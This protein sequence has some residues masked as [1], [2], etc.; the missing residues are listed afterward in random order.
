[1][2]LTDAPFFLSNPHFADSPNAVRLALAGVRRATDAERSQVAIDIFTGAVVEARQTYQLNTVF[3]GGAFRFV[4]VVAT[5][6]TFDI[7]MLLFFS[8]IKNLPN[9]I[10]PIVWVSGLRMLI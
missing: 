2:Q 1:M 5:I 10:V 6:Q 7:M 9:R 3:T 8:S 4:C